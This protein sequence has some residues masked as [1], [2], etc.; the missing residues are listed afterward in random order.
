MPI[1][2]FRGQGLYGEYLYGG[3]Y[4]HMVDS[5]PQY[6]A[7]PSAAFPTYLSPGPI[8]GAIDGTNSVFITGVQIKRARVFRNG[9]L[10]TQNLDC[11]VGSNSV[12][13]LKNSL[14]QVGDSLLFQV[15]L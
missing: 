7:S 13:F 8:S 11:S 14:P 6:F 5:P 3:Y 15:W 1:D 2:Y 4:H 9:I 10:Q 12:V